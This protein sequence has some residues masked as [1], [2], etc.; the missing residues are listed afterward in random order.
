[1]LKSWL[2]WTNISLGILAA[3]IGLAAIGITLV[4]ENEITHFE[5]P[6]IPRIL[7]KTDFKLEKESYD[8]LGEGALELE[9]APLTMQLPDLRKNI[10]YYGKNGRPDAQLQT[11]MLHVAFIGNKTPTSIL[12]DQRAYIKY[13]KTQTPPQFIFSPANTETSLWIEISP[14]GNQAVIKVGMLD[15]KDEIITEPLS[16]AQFTVQEKEFNTRVG[17]ATNWEIGKLRVDGTLLARQKAKWYGMDKFFERHG[18]PEYAHLI[19][20]QRVDFGE[21]E[22]AYSIF[23]GPQSVVIWDGTHWKAM[24]PGADTTGYPLMAVKKIDDRLMTFELWDIEGKS[25]VTLNLLKSTEAWVPQN[26]QQNFKFVGARTRSQFVFEINKER[27]MLSPQDWLILTEHG[28]KKL[29]TP[30]EIDLYLDRKLTGP[31]FVFDGVEKREDK[32]FLL[33]TLFN[34]TRTEMQPIEIPMQQNNKK[35]ESSSRPVPK[36]AQENSREKAVPS[37]PSHEIMKGRPVEERNT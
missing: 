10:I 24:E 23:I 28:W 14:Q 7:P 35:E 26:I 30:E 37:L 29:T 34:S 12:P 32:Q 16:H 11:T 18:G 13:D 36:P 27:I 17:G 21:G 33:G 3:I 6:L 20:K 19:G 31:L 2:A 5:G 25:K 15:D 1:M 22:N 4:R 9:S 8:N